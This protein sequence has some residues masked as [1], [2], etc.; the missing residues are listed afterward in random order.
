MWWMN[1]T[2]YNLHRTNTFQEIWES[3]AEFLDFLKECDVPLAI[4]EEN[5]TT[6]YYLL[7]A[8][9]GNRHIANSDQNQFM[10]AVASTIFMYGPTW[11]KRLFVQQEIRTMSLEELQRGDKSIFNSAY[12]PGTTPSTQTLE[13]LTAINAQNT[14]NHKKG[15]LEAYANLMALLETDVSKE[16]IDRFNPLFGKWA[17]TATPLFYEFNIQEDI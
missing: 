5:A 9:Y 10:Y 2:F 8:R 3:A 17:T 13:E 16:F 7:Y 1:E 4:S 6:L 14:T 12:N 15:K 11:E